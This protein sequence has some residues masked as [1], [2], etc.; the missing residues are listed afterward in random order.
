MV[1]LWNI[2]FKNDKKGK[3]VGTKII[4]QLALAAFRNDP[5]KRR[6]FVD[7]YVAKISALNLKNGLE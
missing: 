1:H 2:R 7:K 4:R 5:S 6:Y 3:K